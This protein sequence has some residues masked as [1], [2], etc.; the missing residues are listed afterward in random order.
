MIMMSEK[1]NTVKELQESLAEE[2]KKQAQEAINNIFENISVSD[3][4]TIP[5]NVFVSNFLSLFHGDI[6]DEDKRLILTQHWVSIAGGP[7]QEVSVVNAKGEEIYRV[8]PIFNSSAVNIIENSR[9]P[10]L[11]IIKQSES[12]DFKPRAVLNLTNNLDIKQKELLANSEKTRQDTINSLNN[13]FMKY[14]L[15]LFGTVENTVTKE[16]NEDDIT[17]E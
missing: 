15:P 7:S 8:P 9:M 16:A 6:T 1:F 4:N 13:I 3:I 10:I 17:Y 2:A 14:K 5:E 12:D 11:D